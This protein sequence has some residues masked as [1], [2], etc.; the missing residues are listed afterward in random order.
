MKDMKQSI[1]PN[2]SVSPGCLLLA[3]VMLY[4]DESLFWPGIL[5]CLLHEMGHFIGIWM[6]GGRVRWLRFTAVGGEMGLDPVFP[7][8]YGGELLA[9]LA[10]P[11]ASLLAAAVG[12]SMRCFLFAGV[13]LSMGVFNLL[14][15]RLLDGGRCLYLTVAMLASPESARAALFWTSVVISAVLLCCGALLFF[16]YLNPTLLATSSWL[17]MEVIR[18]NEKN[19]CVL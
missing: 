16:H 11:A 10:G 3:A 8:S 2:I 15:I 9:T 7:L 14:P 5:A 13:S 1:F 19:P 6:A 4:W 12:G 17:L 18:Q